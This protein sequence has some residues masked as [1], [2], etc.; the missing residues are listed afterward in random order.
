MRLTPALLLSLLLSLLIHT[1]LLSLTFG[2][3]GLWL[4]GF[5]FP[6]QDRRIEAPDLRVIV[7]P[8]QIAAT[9]PAVAPVAEPSQQTVQ[10]PVASGPA[11]TP[12]VASETARQLASLAQ[13]TSRC[14]AVLRSRSNGLPFN[15]VELAF[16]TVRVIPEMVPGIPMPTLEVRINSRSISATPSLTARTVAS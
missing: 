4:P 13:R 11:P 14:N 5:L 1:W 10:Q 6:W 9:E 2:G 16:F 15:H 8:P 7:V 3:Q 12:S